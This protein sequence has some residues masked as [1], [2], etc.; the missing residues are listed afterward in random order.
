MTIPHVSHVSRETST[1]KGL[2]MKKVYIVK[3]NG[4]EIQREYKEI[5]ADVVA[6]DLRNAG[7]MAYVETEEVD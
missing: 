2:V 5:L 1:K 3:V 7:W 6:L 4:E